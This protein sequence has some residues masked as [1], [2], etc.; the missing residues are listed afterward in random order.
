MTDLT[1]IDDGP[2]ATVYSGHRAGVPVALKV[3]PKR[4]DKRT[5]SSFTKEQAK[6]AAVR[7]ITS[8]L[9]V[10]G[11]EELSSGESA[12][13]MALCTQSLAALVERVGPLA[14]ADVAVLGRAMAT[15]L[16]AAHSVGVVH[17]GVAPNNVLFRQTGEPV[18]ADFGV[19]LR[20]A[21]T[22]DP[23]HAIEYLPP[24]TL[25]TGTLNELTDLYGLGAVLHFALSGRSP[26]PGHLGEQP[27][28]RVLRILG[29]PVPAIDRPDVPVGLS[30]LVARL[31]AAAPERRP[32]HATQVADQLTAMLPNQPAPAPQEDWDDFDL[33]PAPPLPATPSEDPLDFDDF[34]AV[35]PNPWSAPHKPTTRQP[36]PTRPAP[37]RTGRPHPVVPNPATINP[38]HDRPAALTPVAA[39]P[40]A[41]HEAPATAYPAAGRATA[42]PAAADPTAHGPAEP[43]VATPAAAVPAAVDPAVAVPASSEPAAANSVVAPAAAEPAAAT[44]TVAEPA[45]NSAGT[46][47]T[48]VKPAAGTSAVVEPTA[49]P[50]GTWPTAVKP[51][52]GTSAVAEPAAANTAGAGQAAAEP[53]AVNSVAPPAAAGPVAA[54]PAAAAASTGAEPAA[55]GPAA[56]AVAGFGAVQPP[57][58]NPRVE[59]LAPVDPAAVDSVATPAAA[60]PAESAAGEAPAVAGLGPARPVAA[61]PL[62]EGPAAAGSPA[63]PAAAEAPAV[64]GLGTEASPPVEG[65]VPVAGWSV[66]L[67]APGSGGPPAEWPPSGPLPLAPSLTPATVEFRK[68]SREFDDDGFSDFSAGRQATVLAAPLA[69]PG[70]GGRRLI[71]YDLLAGAALVLA[72]LALVPL[73]LLRGDPEEIS[74]TPKVPTAGDAGSDVTVELSAPTDLADKVRLSWRA[75]RELDFAVVVAAEGEEKARVLLAE[76]NHTMTVDVEPGRRYCFLVQATDGDRVY[77]SEPVALRGASCRK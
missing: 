4:F 18:L 59:G 56:P 45:A 26:H 13:R 41:A 47:P 73:L 76:Q 70:Q 53:A 77:E 43:T 14:A 32:P 40:S 37:P 33:P 51:A 61:D 62:V 35:H 72:L 49:N 55:A 44:P 69:P 38:T 71:R 42:K 54:E 29:E 5:A 25:R 9:M 65:P 8:I 52:A 24:E 46:W 74:S 50:A 64:A 48:A 6:L 39:N 2:V 68:A 15:A 3:F 57:V 60:R 30:T 7:R 20:Q 1:R 66:G 75:T 22:R 23:L 58:A 67:A 19:T 31:L 16:A 10:D 28:E 34:G 63:E 17:G 11:V 21:F 27:G 36:I 12:V